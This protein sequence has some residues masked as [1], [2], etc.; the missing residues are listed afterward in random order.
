M[1]LLQ[2]YNV[3]Y[4]REIFHSFLGRS[5]NISS[6]VVFSVKIGRGCTH[7]TLHIYYESRM[8]EQSLRALKIC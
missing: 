3:Q 1:S 5:I 7:F 8:P 6:F 2:W 4:W